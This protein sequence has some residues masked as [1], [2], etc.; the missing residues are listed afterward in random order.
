MAAAPQPSYQP[1]ARPLFDATRDGL[2]AFFIGPVKDLFNRRTE[3][4]IACFR[5]G[6]GELSGRVQEVSDKIA[7]LYEKTNKLLRDFTVEHMGKV[8]RVHILHTASGSVMDLHKFFKAAGIIPQDD[9]LPPGV[10]ID[11]NGEA[12]VVGEMSPQVEEFE[13]LKVEH[14][15]LSHMLDEVIAEVEEK[16]R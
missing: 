10:R 9:P 7:A 4:G 11:D 13:A 5:Y 15:E 14:K 3:C 6:Y 8:S 12:D 2:E 1:S 16:K